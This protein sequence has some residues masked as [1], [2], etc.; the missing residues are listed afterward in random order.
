MDDETC[1]CVEHGIQPI[2]FVCT[3]ISPAPSGETVGFVSYAPENAD[4]LRDAW[5][6][7]CEA[8]LQSH[9]GEWVEGSVEVP[10]GISII[11]AE[12]YRRRENEAARAG[13]RKIHRIS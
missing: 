7:S 13:R 11:C 8:Y 10:G 3:H 4:D 1:E 6:D 5:R 12:C 2:T 9:G